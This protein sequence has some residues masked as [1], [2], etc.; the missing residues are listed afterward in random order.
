MVISRLEPLVT[1]LKM[2][3]A[4]VKTKVEPVILPQKV[5]PLSIRSL[6]AS[7]TSSIASIRTVVSVVSQVINIQCGNFRSFLSLRFYV[8]L[9]FEN[10]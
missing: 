8:K 2:S 10:M 9:L 4:F 6:H 1:F 5:E 7:R 3:A